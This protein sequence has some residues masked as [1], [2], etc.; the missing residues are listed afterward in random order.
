MNPGRSLNR[1]CA[2]P[3]S[4]TIPFHPFRILMSCRISLLFSRKASTL[5]IRPT[6][7]GESFLAH[8]VGKETANLL[9][10]FHYS[11]T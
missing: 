3:L 11:H 5:R 4:L 10:L 1:S 2:V 6:L 7:R 9:P 8:D